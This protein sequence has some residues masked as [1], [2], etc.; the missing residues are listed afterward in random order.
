M[1]SIIVYFSLRL[2]E[3]LNIIIKVKI[4]SHP[5]IIKMKLIISC[6]LFFC[7]CSYGQDCTSPV[8][9][10]S[11]GVTIRWPCP[12]SQ[13]IAPVGSTTVKFECSYSYTGVYFTFWNITDIEPIVGVNPPLNSDIV[14]TVDGGGSG[15]VT[16]ISLPVTKQSILN[17]QCGL[18]NNNKAECIQSSLQTTVI[19]L[20]VQLISFGK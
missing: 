8:Y 18:C 14:V 13:V 9:N 19:S 2:Y 16:T 17:V 7:L 5:L 6:C 11:A 4:K 1:M 3:S 12:S 20:P 15:G 10:N